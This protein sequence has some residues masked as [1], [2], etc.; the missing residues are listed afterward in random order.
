MEKF[1]NA[2]KSVNK[3]GLLALVLVAFSTLAFKAPTKDTDVLYKRDNISGVWSPVTTSSYYCDG[4]LNICTQ[5]YPA[6]KN[7]TDNPDDY[8]EETPGVYTPF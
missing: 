2:L 5:L 4:D 6:G 7:P 8:I 1:K 3:F